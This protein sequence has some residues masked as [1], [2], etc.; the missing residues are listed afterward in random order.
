MMM[1]MMRMMI[2]MIFCSMCDAYQ[3]SLAMLVF[4]STSKY[5]QTLSVSF[6]GQD[7]KNCFQQGIHFRPHLDLLPTLVSLLTNLERTLSVSDNTL[8]LIQKQALR[9]YFDR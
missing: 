8:K 5:Y 1:M 6:L 2:V 3:N 4:G 9:D 7:T